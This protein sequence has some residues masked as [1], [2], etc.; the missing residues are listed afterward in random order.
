[1]SEYDENCGRNIVLD[2]ANI[3]NPLQFA[4]QQERM[5]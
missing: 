3:A 2:P 4:G 1:M 5:L